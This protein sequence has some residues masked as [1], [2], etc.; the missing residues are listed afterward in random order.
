MIILLII[1]CLDLRVIKGLLG[2]QKKVLRAKE[3]RGRKREGRR[4]GGKSRGERL[5][6]EGNGEKAFHLIK[7]RVLKLSRGLFWKG[8]TNK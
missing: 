3:G 4:R 1:N 5:M 8:K 6:T 2:K 7:T